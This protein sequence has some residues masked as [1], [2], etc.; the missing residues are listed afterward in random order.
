MKIE[1]SRTKVNQGLTLFEVLVSI[2]IIG[3]IAVFMAIAIPTSISLSGSTDEM[4][5][6]T[7][8]AQK[9][10]EDVKSEF[11]FDQSLFD[12]LQEGTTPPI[13]VTSQHTNSGEYNLQTSITIENTAIVNDIEVPTLAILKVTVSPSNIEGESDQ[14]VSF[15]TKLRRDR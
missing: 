14:T 13:T 8:L 11:N 4:E 1:Y 10:I 6:T 2:L 12:N 7:I 9:Y 5:S 3:I 15:S